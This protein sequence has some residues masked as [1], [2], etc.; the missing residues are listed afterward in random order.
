MHFSRLSLFM[1][2]LVH[3]MYLKDCAYSMCRTSWVN[4]IF[5]LRLNVLKEE[6]KEIEKEN[7]QIADKFEKIFNEKKIKTDWTRSIF[8]W[9]QSL[10][11]RLDISLLPLTSE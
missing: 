6:L 10:I 2:H 9:F 3:K 5:F 11:N 1:A 8:D 4:F 7:S